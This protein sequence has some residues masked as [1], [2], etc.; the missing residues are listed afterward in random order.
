[1]SISAG[2]TSEEIQAFVAEYQLQP[3]G[4]KGSWL[5]EQGVPY[6]RLQRWRAAVFEGDLDRGLIPRQGVPMTVTPGTRTALERARARERVAYDTEVARL[7]ARVGE[8]ESANEALGKA[9][10]LL[11]S[12]NVHEPDATPAPTDPLSSSTPRTPSS[13]P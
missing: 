8:L 3:L 9:I 5:A 12:R 10:G 13:P 11:H 6:G 1:M 2:Y 7:N 4:R